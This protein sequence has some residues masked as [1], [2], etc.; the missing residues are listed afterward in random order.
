MLEL[1][2]FAFLG[3]F[4][5]TVF[6]DQPLSLS[7][8][9]CKKFRSYRALLAYPRSSFKSSVGT[10]FICSCAAQTYNS[11]QKYVSFI[12]HCSDVLVIYI[13]SELALWV[14]SFNLYFTGR[15]GSFGLALA[16]AALW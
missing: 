11:I 8:K 16:N 6:C 1:D 12:W 10:C 15:K 13:F 9:K 7:S 5:F 14:G 3:S 4:F 2:Y